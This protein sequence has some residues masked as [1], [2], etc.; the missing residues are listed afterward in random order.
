MA[1]FGYFI[2]SAELIPT[3]I[4]FLEEKVAF[5]ALIGRA[6]ASID[7]A[8]TGLIAAHRRQKPKNDRRLMGNA[9][10]KQAFPGEKTTLP[11]IRRA[12]P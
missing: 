7:H 11:Q 2:V 10:E 1:G 8:Q 4:R 12:I 3:L 6:K 9:R 5:E